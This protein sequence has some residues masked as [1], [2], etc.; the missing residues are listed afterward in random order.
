MDWIQLFRANVS[1]SASLCKLSVWAFA[2]WKGSVKRMKHL[3]LESSGILQTPTA[4]IFLATIREGSWVVLSVL[5]Q[6]SLSCKHH[7]S[8][9]DK[10]KAKWK[11]PQMD[12]V[13]CAM[14]RQGQGNLACPVT[15]FLTPHWCPPD[16]SPHCGA[17]WRWTWSTEP[18]FVRTPILFPSQWW[19]PYGS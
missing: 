1:T 10:T 2:K 14:R 8:S 5:I 11:Q 6:D 9:W 7:L 17:D 15:R 13:T 12:T 18:G 19:A 3:V 16:G 4:K